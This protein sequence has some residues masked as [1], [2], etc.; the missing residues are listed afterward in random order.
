MRSA[1]LPKNESQR[2]QALREYQILDTV[3]EHIFDTITEICSLIC[4]TPI[5]LISI[6]DKD[7]QWFKSKHGL[8]ATETPRNISFCAHAIHGSDVMEIQDATKD[9]RFFDNPLVTQDPHVRF[10]AG[11]P[12]IN[13]QGYC[14]GALCVI[15]HKPQKLTNTQKI[16]LQKMSEIIMMHFEA[17]KKILDD[18]AK[19]KQIEKKLR[20]N[21]SYQRAILQ[22]VS[23]GIMTLDKTGV[24]LSINKTILTLFEYT[25]EEILH[26]NIKM[27]LPDLHGNLLN[28]FN[29][30]LRGRSKTGGI[31]HVELSTSLLEQEGSEI[32]VAVVRDITERKKIELM[33]NQFISTVSHELRTPLTSIRGS[34]G[35]IL[36]ETEGPLTNEMR[37]FLQIANSNT[38]R[39]I[40]LIN[41]I[42]EIEK[43]ENGSMRFDFDKVNIIDLVA[44]CIE[45]NQSYTKSDLHYVL[46]NTNNS[47]YVNGDK[48]R[49]MQV[50]VNLLSNAAKF[51]PE[52]G[53]VLVTVKKRQNK[54]RV[55]VSDQ[56]PGI[57]LDFQPRI[58]EKFSQSE[59][60]SLKKGGTGLGLCICKNFIEK[61]GGKIKFETELGKGS[62]FYF[63]LPQHDN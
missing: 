25:K 26:N 60:S 7:R 57:P 2:L 4:N 62:T 1:T 28:N 27:L 10:Y 15:N 52:N 51:S 50:I 36:A 38:E 61:M 20:K 29:K 24:I 13:P 40:L 35:L 9:S 39:L 30:E 47:L 42:L 11:M 32:I 44:E 59:E 19:L 45:L 54:I 3:E 31:F 14:F 53:T 12:L 56:G 6:V 18:F 34:L 46:E 17:R 49:L 16:I 43:F 63:D 41:D 48:N 37:Y 58:F 33:K 23:E 5:S 22:S 55:S 8:Q 21:E